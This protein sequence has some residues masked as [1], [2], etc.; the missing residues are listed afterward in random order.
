VR[1]AVR[2]A[3]VLAFASI[4][5]TKAMFQDLPD[6][7]GKGGDGTAGRGGA[8]G[9]SGEGGFGGTG[10]GGGSVA[11]GN[12]GG[13]SGGGAGVGG[14]G[15]GAGTAGG[16]AAGTGVGGRG[17]AGGTGGLAGTGGI[18]G[19][20]GSAGTAG[21]AG[22]GGR[23]GGAGT[24]GGGASGTGAGGAGG[25]GGAGGAGG[26]MGTRPTVAGQIVITELQHNAATI[27]DDLGEWFE[28][29]N[30]STTVTYDLLGCEVTD[31][32][33]S[34]P[35]ISANLVLPPMSY[36][37]LAVSATPGFTPDYVYTPPNTPP[38]VKFNNSAGDRAAIYCGG[39]L[40]DEF[41]Y[42]TAVSG[43]E[44]HSFSLDPRHLN[45]MDNDV[46]MTYWC[47][48]RDTMPG[49]AYDSSGPNYGTPGRANP[50]CPGVTQ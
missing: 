24:A 50:Q 21:S 37:V 9:D 16:G 6:S 20:G 32:D 13:G 18:A 14:R 4:A 31:A 36:K 12:G 34:G 38:P 22:V 42:T 5:C 43:V 23:G 30:P 3:L 28:V 44:G 41:P 26:L 48:A 39:V 33:L 1:V 19:T 40:I 35:A 27:S 15:G 7:S 2:L 46:T 10:G 45:W 8:S 17:G 29:Y 47:N 49:D 25:T 11:G